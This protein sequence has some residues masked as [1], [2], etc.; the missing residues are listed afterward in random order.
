ML[1]EKTVE[2]IYVA[3]I[4]GVLMEGEN[5]GTTGASLYCLSLW[6]IGACMGRWK[7]QISLSLFGLSD[8]GLALTIDEHIF[9]FVTL[10]DPFPFL[11]IFFCNPNFKIS[12]KLPSQ[13]CLQAKMERAY[14]LWM[15]IMKFIGIFIQCRK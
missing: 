5:F 15:K 7:D 6:E 14:S 1:W 3:Y 13:Q 4:W 9:Y 10:F 12:R 2:S 8:T 11:V